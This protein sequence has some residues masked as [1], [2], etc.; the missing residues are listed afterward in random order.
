MGG[1]GVL[2]SKFALG[3]AV[4]SVSILGFQ[5]P[6]HR[7]GQ[8]SFVLMGPTSSELLELSK[9]GV[10]LGWVDISELNVCAVHAEWL[11]RFGAGVRIAE[12]ADDRATVPPLD[13]VCPAMSSMTS[14]DENT[15]DQ[16]ARKT[17]FPYA[18]QN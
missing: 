16:T 10:L 3:I 1:C 7:L 12:P 4:V 17:E 9:L 18:G 6:T 8:C 11:T 15:I 14:A 5:R 13:A 2:T